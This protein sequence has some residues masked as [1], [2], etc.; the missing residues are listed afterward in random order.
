MQD[1]QGQPDYRRINIK[2]VGIKNISYPITVLDRARHIQRTVARVNMYVNL[3][4]HFKGTHMSR[5]VEILNR[6]HGEINLESM[7]RILVEMKQRLR[8][9]AAHLEIEFPYFVSD[10]AAVAAAPGRLSAGPGEA[11]IGV[12]EYRCRMHGSLAE[13]DDLA[14]E[15]RIPI[16]PPRPPAHCSGLPRSLGHWGTADI[17]LRFRR[18]VWI[19]EI[20]ALAAS[21]TRH[22]LCWPLAEPAA[23]TPAPADPADCREAAPE[24]GECALAVENLARALGKKLQGHPDIRQYS[25]RVENLAAGFS[26]FATISGGEPPAGG[27]GHRDRK[28]PESGLN[29]GC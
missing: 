16:A 25:V 19:E 27:K 13:K 26:T 6:F 18:F 29:P 21:V 24:Q 4:H 10:P 12:C 22:D 8:A 15:I 1:I 20:I 28:R 14:L 5:F 3:P 17:C 23:A 9:E 7:H 11:G 2:K